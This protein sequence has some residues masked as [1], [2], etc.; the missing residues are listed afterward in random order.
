MVF[1][2]DAHRVG[3]IRRWHESWCEMSKTRWKRPHTGGFIGWPKYAPKGIA[4]CPNKGIADAH[5]EKSF[6]NLNKLTRNHVV[7]TIF[8]LIWNSKRTSVWFQICDFSRLCEI[9]EMVNPLGQC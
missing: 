4:L 7:F 3:N 8:R 5:A 2:Y 6:P 1:N 9:L